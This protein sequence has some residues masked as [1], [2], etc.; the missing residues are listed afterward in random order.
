MVQ[1]GT[2]TIVDYPVA[3][4]TNPNDITINNFVVAQNYNNP[5]TIHWLAIGY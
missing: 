3:I 4:N 1:I 5:I 2:E